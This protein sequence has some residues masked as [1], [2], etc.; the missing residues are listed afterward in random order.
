MNITRQVNGTDLLVGADDDPNAVGTSAWIEREQ[1]VYF[2][3]MAR[4]LGDPGDWSTFR[5]QLV[6]A[7]RAA[8]GLD[9][10]WLHLA[11]EEQQRRRAARIATAYEVVDAVRGGHDPLTQWE[12]FSD[13][14]WAARM[15]LTDPAA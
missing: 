15:P 14:L 4:E 6:A 2:V 11:A 8:W 1:F 7:L 9:T 12:A 3:T 5:D 13:A 10:I